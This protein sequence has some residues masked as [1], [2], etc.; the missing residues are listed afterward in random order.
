MWLK[1]ATHEWSPQWLVDRLSV[2][3]RQI[4]ETWKLNPL[5]IL[6]NHV[7][8][9]PD[10]RDGA[11]AWL[12]QLNAHFRFYPETFF[13]AVSILDRF[14]TAVKAQPKYL[15]CIAITCLYLGSKTCEE[16]DVSI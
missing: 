3:K 12:A 13:Q 14:L 7:Q 2:I 1:T 11:V 8:I 15:R 9:G 4:K 16:E 6:P 5:T 10:D